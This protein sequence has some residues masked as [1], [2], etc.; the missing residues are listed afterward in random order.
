MVQFKIRVSQNLK[1][2]GNKPTQKYWFWRRIHQDN[3]WEH[4]SSSFWL[5]GLSYNQQFF[6]SRMSIIQRVGWTRHVHD[7]LATNSRQFRDDLNVVTI[8]L[9]FFPECIFAQPQ[10]PAVMYIFKTWFEGSSEP[11]R[12][13]LRSCAKRTNVVQA[14]CLD[15]DMVIWP[16]FQ[17]A[18][19]SK[20]THPGKRAYGGCDCF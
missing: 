7:K 10:Q 3:S 2:L 20:A 15:V 14:A 12:S 5:L 11:A 1:T 17:K 16:V 4:F 8:S 19:A 18:P 6:L 13:E 9:L